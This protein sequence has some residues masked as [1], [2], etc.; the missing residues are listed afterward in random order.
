MAVI[1]SAAVSAGFA[2]SR[3]CEGVAVAS[4]VTLISCIKGSYPARMALSRQPRSHWVDR[5][6]AP[7]IFRRLRDPGP[8]ADVPN[9]PVA[10]LVDA[11]ELKIEFRKECWFDSGQGHHASLLFNSSP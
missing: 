3:A 7:A 10:E 2:A 8:W 1:A 4:K 6:G 9:A 5:R 11:L